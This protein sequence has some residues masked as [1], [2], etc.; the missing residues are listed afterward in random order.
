MQDCVNF[1]LT[2]RKLESISFHLLSL[3]LYFLKMVIAL[4]R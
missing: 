2:W 3:L 1:T 4:L